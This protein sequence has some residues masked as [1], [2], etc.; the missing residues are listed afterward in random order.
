MKNLLNINSDS[1]SNSKLLFENPPV[2]TIHQKVLG[3]LIGIEQHHQLPGSVPESVSDQHVILIGYKPLEI[4]IQLGGEFRHQKFTANECIINPA[5]C[6]SSCCWNESADFMIFFIEP[7]FV[8]R[9][10]YESTN[11]YM[12]EIMPSFPQFDGL[13]YEITSRFRSYIELAKLPSQIYVDSLGSFLVN[14]LVEI[15]STSKLVTA[16]KNNTFSTSDLQML[17]TYILDRIYTNISLN[18]LADLFNIC[19]P[20][21]GKRLKESIGISPYQ[22]LIKIRISEAI[23]LLKSTKKDLNEIAQLTGFGNVTNLCRLF[24]K[25]LDTSPDTFRQ[26]HRCRGDLSPITLIE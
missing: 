11:L 19:V 10:C 26:V 21:F 22:Y 7:R 2:R 9:A 3:D 8:E 16:K 1:I 18:E 20:Y 4:D 6:P 25:R 17:N 5:Y 15:Y 13:I 24:K 12:P 14:H 23:K